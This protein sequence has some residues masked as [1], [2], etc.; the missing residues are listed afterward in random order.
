VGCVLRHGATRCGGQADSWR[1]VIHAGKQ[2][3]FWVGLFDDS[4]WVISTNP[5]F[6]TGSKSFAE[7]VGRC[8]N[9]KRS[10]ASRVLRAP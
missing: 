6:K 4:G 7:N 8:Y 3:V 2:M 5:A 9:S 1:S 10:I